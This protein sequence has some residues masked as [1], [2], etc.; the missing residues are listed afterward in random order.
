MFL[1]RFFLC[2]FAFL[3]VGCLKNRTGPFIEDKARD[4]ILDGRLPEM[5]QR[6]LQVAQNVKEHNPA[7]VIGSLALSWGEQI[8]YLFRPAKK[9][10]KNLVILN[11]GI[12][13]VEAPYGVFM[14]HKLLKSCFLSESFDQDDTAVLIVHVMNPSGLL[15]GRRAN[16]NNVDLNRNCFAKAPEF[17]GLAIKNKNYNLHKDFFNNGPT[18][19]FELIVVALSSGFSNLAKAVGG[20]Y[21]DPTGLNFGGYDYQEETVAVQSLLGKYIP[22]FKNILIG[23]FHTG[24]GDFG[25]NQLMVNPLKKEHAHQA[26]QAYQ[27]EIKLIQQLFPKNECEGVC[28]VLLP[29]AHSY[30][31]TG[32]FSKWV[33]SEFPKKRL[34]GRVLSFTI[35]MGTLSG[36]TVLEA[37]IDENYCHHNPQD[38]SKKRRQTEERRLRKAFSPDSRVWRTQVSRASQQLCS[39]LKRF[40]HL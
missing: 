38:C 22:D 16:G 7:T 25:I 21:E 19:L 40:S 23:D 33:Y 27:E 13:G 14:Q 39:A 8:D 24:L 1:R 26:Q 17:P 34:E 30:P 36:P 37:L 15:N 29:E 12:H 18:N 10:P 11:S 2:L 3:Q 35:E 20:Q 31:V 5:R 28:E 6:F 4:Q 9:E 32:D